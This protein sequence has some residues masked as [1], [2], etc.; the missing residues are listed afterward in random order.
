[1]QGE[2]SF[3]ESYQY[4]Q[5]REKKMA[6]KFKIIEDAKRQIRSCFL[7]IAVPHQPS[8]ADGEYGP[9]RSEKVIKFNKTALRNMGKIKKEKVDPRLVGGSDL[10]VDKVGKPGSKD[11]VEALRAFYEL[12]NMAGQETSAFHDE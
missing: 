2:K 8:L 3:L 9:I 6:T 12:Q 1:M 4:H 11:R 10:M 7:G 5:P